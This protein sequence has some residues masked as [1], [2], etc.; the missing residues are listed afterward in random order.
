[1]IYTH[2]VAWLLLLGVGLGTLLQETNILYPPGIK[3]EGN[4][5]NI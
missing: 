3:F 2:G 5:W 4:D 1:M